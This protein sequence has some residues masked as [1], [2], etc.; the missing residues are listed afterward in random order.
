[1]SVQSASGEQWRTVVYQSARRRSASG[2]YRL[3]MAEPSGSLNDVE[4]SPLQVSVVIPTRE[5]VELTCR[6]LESLRPQVDAGVEIVV[7]D[8]ASRDGT[9]EA[10]AARFPEV[11]LL[12]QTERRGFTAAVNR[13]LDAATGGLLIALNSDTELLPGSLAA[14]LAGFA[15]EEHLGVAGARLVYPDGTPQWSGGR[16]PGLLW[17]FGLASGL[18]ALL[19]LLPVV[20]TVAG[21]SRARRSQPRSTGSPAPRWLFAGRSGRAWGRSMSRTASTARTSISASGRG[22]PAGRWR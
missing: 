5:T 16:E 22:T 17:L 10:I 3:R 8:D 9:A 7:V 12:R 6:C 2:Y 4:P 18:P 11:R 1:M 20:E 21:P 19:G 14:L 15:G 13:G